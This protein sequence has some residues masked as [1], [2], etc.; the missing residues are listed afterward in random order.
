MLRIPTSALR[1]GTRARHCILPAVSFNLNF[2]GL[3]AIVS[4]YYLFLLS[5]GTL[6]ILAPE[7]LDKVFDNMLVHLLHGEFTVDRD[8]IDYEAV[9]QDGKTYAYSPCFPQSCGSW[10]CRS[11]T[12]RT[13]ISHGCP[14]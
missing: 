2:I 1:I 3:V 11:S 4:V 8:A 6:Q 12:L 5:N 14:V 7:L 9:T 13:P 10:R